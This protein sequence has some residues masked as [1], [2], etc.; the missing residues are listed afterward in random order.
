M[1]PIPG[2]DP[3]WEGQVRR[4][5]PDLPRKHP[6]VARMLSEGEVFSHQAWHGLDR[7]RD[8]ALLYIHAA[9]AAVPNSV[10][11]EHDRW[12]EDP[13]IVAV[14]V[15]GP[16]T[17]ECRLRAVEA[18][19]PELVRR[20]EDVWSR[21]TIGLGDWYRPPVVHVAFGFGKPWNPLWPALGLL[22]RGRLEDQLADVE[23]LGIDCQARGNVG[24]V[25][26]MGRWAWRINWELARRN[27]AGEPTWTWDQVDLPKSERIAI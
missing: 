23:E 14:R 18:R 10:C 6:D 9:H 19:V 26:E 5:T 2:M 7:Q 22:S 25:T 3:W 4:V 21:E 27:R 8:V 15:G 17:E 16:H 12:E 20:A 24:K 1:N 11:S 13:D